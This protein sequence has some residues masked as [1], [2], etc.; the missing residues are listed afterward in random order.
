MTT[1]Y[2]SDPN[3]IENGVQ[4]VYQ[5]IRESLS[6]ILRWNFQRDVEMVDISLTE[7]DDA[8]SNNWDELMSSFWQ[9][10]KQDIPDA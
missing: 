5:E 4:Q 6:L 9:G 1:T 7:L 10:V 8:I 3:P 2:D